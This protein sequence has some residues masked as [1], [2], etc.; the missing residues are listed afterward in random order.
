ME[1]RHRYQVKVLWNDTSDH[2]IINQIKEELLDDS[3]PSNYD[4]LNEL[5]DYL[6]KTK[7]IDRFAGTVFHMKTN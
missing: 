2:R 1:L 7:S 3:Y 4:N 5:T 6:S